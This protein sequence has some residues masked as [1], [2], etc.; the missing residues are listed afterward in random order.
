MTREEAWRRAKGCLYDTLSGKEA[1]EIIEALEQE[2]DWI[3]VSERLPEDGSY[4]AAVKSIVGEPRI[5]IRSFAKDLNK[6]D[7][8]DFPKHKCGWYS[9]DSEYGFWEDTDVIAW[10]ELPEPY[11]MC[12]GDNNE[13]D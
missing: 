1:D 2:P 5:S 13:I 10:C 8:F 9:Y 3:P 4:L 11:K 6:V 7:K 12:G